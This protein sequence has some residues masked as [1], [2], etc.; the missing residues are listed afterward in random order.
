MFNSI[1]K[2]LIRRFDILKVVKEVF[3]MKPLE[4]ISF[5]ISGLTADIDTVEKPDGKY[6]RLR[7][8][9]FDFKAVDEL[10]KIGESGKV[11]W[12]HSQDYKDKIKEIEK[13]ETKRVTEQFKN[14]SFLK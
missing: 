13:R 8:E 11:D 4:I 2:F 10:I 6:L 7:V 14:N 5:V 3:K 1:L 9:L 12:Y